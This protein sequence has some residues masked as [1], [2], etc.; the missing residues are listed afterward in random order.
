MASIRIGGMSNNTIIKIIATSVVS[1]AALSMLAGCSSSTSA[2]DRILAKLDSMQQ[3]ID[4]LKNGR[5]TGSSTGSNDAKGP[6]SGSQAT[7]SGNG[8]NGTTSSNDFE[9]TIADLEKRAASASDAAKK[10][11]VPSNPA[12]RPRAYM[13]AKAPLEK[14]D[15]ETDLVDDQLEA[16]MRS[17]QIDRQTYFQYEQRLD[18]I[19]DTL[20]RADDHL[21][22]SMGVDD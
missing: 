7:D 21:E 10:A 18:A 17:N 6:D 14:L 9:K 8:S 2:E 20:D 12:D 3:E 19:D 11:A 4:D 13:D 1:L 15:N 16:A 22:L 5:D